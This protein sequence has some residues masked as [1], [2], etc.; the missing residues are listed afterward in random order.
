MNAI[1]TGKAVRIMLVAA[2]STTTRTVVFRTL[3]E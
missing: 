1:A 2:S 3:T